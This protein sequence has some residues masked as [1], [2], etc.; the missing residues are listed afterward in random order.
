MKRISIKEKS[1][2]AAALLFSGLFWAA[3]AW[4]LIVSA[5]RYLPVLG[6][7]RAGIAHVVGLLAATVLLVY[8]VRL[9]RVTKKMAFLRGHAVEV[10]PKQSPELH[11]R[12]GEVCERL[13]I[14]DIPELANH[15]CRRFRPDAKAHQELL[16]PEAIDALKSH[17]WPGNVRE[18][19]NVIEHAT[20]LCDQPPIVSMKIEQPGSAKV[21][22]QP[23]GFDFLRRLDRA[24]AF[25]DRLAFDQLQR[26]A[27]ALQHQCEIG[28]V[29]RQPAGDTLFA[30]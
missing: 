1:L 27:L 29:D 5:E 26:L 12:I 19:A 15:L 10:G 28:A 13:Q 21:A 14:D 25:H 7:E 22:D 18:L 3:L 20:I 8:A 16:T 23:Q 2:F 30:Q 11:A 4:V 9:L 6:L 24:R 17:S